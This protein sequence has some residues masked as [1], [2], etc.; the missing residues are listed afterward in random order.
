M[1]S[2]LSPVSIFR[3]RFQRFQIDH[4]RFVFLSVGRKTALQFRHGHESVHSGRVRYFAN[5]RVLTQDRQ[6]QLLSRAKGRDAARLNRSSKCPSRLRLQSVS[7]LRSGTLRCPA[8]SRKS[9]QGN[10]QLCIE[11][12][13]ALLNFLLNELLARTALTLFE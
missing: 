11:K 3:N 8:P 2:G 12:S 9:D 7:Q 5:D 10:S 4:A 13:N 1:A 6:R